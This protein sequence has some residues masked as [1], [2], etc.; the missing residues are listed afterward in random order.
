MEAVANAYRQIAT[1]HSRDQLIVDHLA[2]VRHLLG[3]VVS[4][5]PSG[6]DV[7]NLEA[8]GILGLVEAAGQFDA[9]RGVPFKTFAYPRIRG[10][11]LDELRRN[12]PL[13]QHMLQR[14]SAIRRAAAALG[15]TPTVE[16]LA[17]ATQLPIEEVEEC[18]EAIRMTRPEAWH[19][20][21]VAPSIIRRIDPAQGLEQDEDKALLAEAVE[22]L[23]RQERLV[24]SMYYGDDM[25][26]KE[27]GD[28]LGLSE[29]RISRI[30]A[31]AQLRL[32]DYVGRRS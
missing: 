15:A 5:L 11:I 22:S 12:C 8:A 32:K 19:E 20:D 16:A 6:V 25:R 3:R 26:L 28:V 21:L 10:A 18:L 29:S 17:K 31:R 24:V 7:E 27:I 30:L 13:P 23:P 1:R 4:G 14:W 9:T 2:F